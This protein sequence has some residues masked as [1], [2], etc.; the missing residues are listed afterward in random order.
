MKSE[1]KTFTLENGLLGTMF[2]SS[3]SIYHN[4]IHFLFAMMNFDGIVMARYHISMATFVQTHT[5]TDRQMYRN[6]G[7]PSKLQRAKKRKK[8]VYL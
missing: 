2:G 8:Y 1:T 4:W 3:R 5:H 7:I 6:K